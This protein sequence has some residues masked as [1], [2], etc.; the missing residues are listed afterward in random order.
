MSVCL[1]PFYLLLYSIPFTLS[2]FTAP[3]VSGST[4][5]SHFLALHCFAFEIR[6]SLCLRSPVQT[7]SL[8]YLFD[9]FFYSFIMLMLSSGV[10]ARTNKVQC[11][12]RLYV[13]ARAK[14]CC[15]TCK[16]QMRAK[17]EISQ[18]DIAIILNV[19]QRVKV[20]DDI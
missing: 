8:L 15:N 13:C 3:F 19:V 6:F 5:L 4:F 20:R 16:R 2:S 10:C 14:E 17:N 1:S 12:K 11:T 9:I 7:T 18:N